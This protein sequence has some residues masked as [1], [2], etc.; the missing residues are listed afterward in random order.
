MMMMVF[1]VAA[2]A[3]VLAYVGVRDVGWQLD[4]ED[5]VGAAPVVAGVVGG[6]VSGVVGV[7]PAVA[8]GMPWEVV[9][10]FVAGAAGHAAGGIIALAFGEVLAYKESGNERWRPQLFDSSVEAI[11]EVWCR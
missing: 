4:D 5:V 11:G 2:A 3:T 8:A 10:K 6:G 1:A 7:L 9:L